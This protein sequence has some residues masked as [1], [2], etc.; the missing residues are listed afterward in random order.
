MCKD[1]DMITITIDNYRDGKVVYKM[2]ENAVINLFKATMMTGKNAGKITNIEISIACSDG[3]K[4]IE[5]GL[6]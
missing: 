1:N 2:P 6:N 4:I 5:E 3:I